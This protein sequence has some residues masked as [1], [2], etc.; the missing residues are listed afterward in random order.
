MIAKK[1]EYTDF[2]NLESTSVTF[3]PGTNVLWGRNAQGKTNILEGIY[4]FARGKSFRASAD[5]ELVGFGKSL[6]RAELTFSRDDSARDT[7][8]EA[9]I[10][11]SGKKRLVRNLATLSGAAEMIGEFTAV[12]FCPEHLSLV[13]GSPAERRGFLDVALA[14]LSPQYVSQLRRYSH[15]LDQRNALIRAAREGDMPSRESWEAFASVMAPCAQ[16]IAKAR[17]DYTEKLDRFAAEHF[18]KMTDGGETPDIIYKSNI[19]SDS[20]GEIDLARIEELLCS[21]TEREVKAGTTLYGVHRDDIIIRLNSK[22]AKVY[23]SQGQK[24]SLSLAMK[25]AEGEISKLSMGE[26]PVF[27]LDDVLSELDFVRRT[28][29]LGALSDRQL[30]VTSCEPELF[31]QMENVNLIQVENGHISGEIPEG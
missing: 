4:Y 16:Y 11:L 8:L 15:A 30:I 28:Y 25:L 24:R 5:R 9:Y 12:M 6:C 31:S 23:S 26:Y 3:L 19:I 27:L 17:R 2:R 10:P 21:N 22:E 20:D 1:I 14:Q 18:R 29:I 7:V 13:S